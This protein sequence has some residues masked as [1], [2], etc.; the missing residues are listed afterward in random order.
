MEMLSYHQGKTVESRIPLGNEQ[1]RIVA[2]TDVNVSS[3]QLLLQDLLATSIVML[4]DFDNV[5]ARAK[6]EIQQSPRIPHFLSLLVHHGLLTTYQADRIESGKTHGLIL[7]NYRVLNRLGAGGMGVVFQAEHRDMRRPVAIKVLANLAEQDPRI[8][9]RFLTEIRV[10]A[11]LQH[12]NI[13]AAMDAGTVHSPD[14]PTL[15]YF[16]MECVPGHDLEEYVRANGP[17]SAVQ[18]CDVIHQIAS[19]LAEAHKHH[20]VHRDIKPSNIRLTPEG[21]AKLLDFGLARHFTFRVTE[22]GVLLGTLDFMA[23]EQMVNA[24]GVDIR[25]DIYALGGTLFWCLTATNPFAAQ[26]N[27]VRQITYRQTAL[28][29][30]IRCLRPEIPAELDAIVARMMSL[31]PDDRYAT[32]E[33]VMQAF[34]PFLKPEM[35][36]N[37]APRSCR[38]ELQGTASHEDSHQIL[39]V[40]DEPQLR[41]I[42]KFM[43]QTEGGP[44]CDEAANGVLA[45][46]KIRA[47]RYDLVLLDIDMPEMTGTEVCR[48]L[49]ENPPYAN[50][51]VIMMSGR[52]SPD[53]MARMLLNGADDYLVK[54]VSAI[55]LQSKVKAALRLKDAQDRADV[56][57]SHLLAV[58]H[59]LEK[60]LRAS[61]SD[62]VF[63]RNGLLNALA[64]LVEYREGVSGSHLVRMEHYVR[65]L[66]EAAA[67]APAFFGQI[68]ANFVELLVCCAPLHDLGKVGLPDHILLK[69]GKLEA[70]E[71]I[72]METHTTIGADTLN[73]VMKQHGSALAFLQMAADIARHHHEHFDGTGYPDALTGQQIPL[74]ARIVAIC[75]VYD[76]LRCRRSYK[77]ALSHSTTV[78]VMTKVSA[79][80][81]DANL[82]HV[83]QACAGQFEQTFRALP[84]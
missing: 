48:Q 30:S 9:Q 57:S 36:D 28:P 44:R 59:E 50:L 61:N 19:A 25:A 68:D 39:I 56:L 46:Q 13:V 84:D 79:A 1:S 63:A 83:F 49:R 33:L 6:N 76:A 42:N 58:N 21:Q 51:K 29:P 4:E 66:A 69:P 73:A 5:P 18:A 43:L 40:D 24:G 22:P 77:P 70:D 37:V 41:L 53:E 32:P 7:G 80:Q 54:P 45:L 71:R 52:A 78:Q 2:N 14:L 35:R 10:V 75:D 15:R 72:L 65:G 67:K 47:K 38:L 34:L 31:D 74:S 12:P 64:K 3:P 26:P 27:I 16:V 62:L 23:P 81:F 8:Q 55:Q 82:L 17:L 20:L 60:T 11:Q